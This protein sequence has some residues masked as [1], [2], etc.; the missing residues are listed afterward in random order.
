MNQQVADTSTKILDLIGPEGL[1]AI[2]GTI[3]TVRTIRALWYLDKKASFV[4]NLVVAS[5]IGAGFVYF[6]KDMA[7]VKAVLGGAFMTAIGS[8]I[9]YE[10]LKWFLA[11]TYEKTGLE[12]LRAL[13][14]FLSPKPI[15]TKVNGMTQETPPHEA[16]TVFFD[17]TRLDK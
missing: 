12:S 17:K 7:T 6:F 15:K 3:V 16:L 10:G 2:A 9:A 1:L 8:Q 14:F 11:I 5:L 13:F 4:I